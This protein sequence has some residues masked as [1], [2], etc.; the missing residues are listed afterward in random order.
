MNQVALTI[1]SDID[2]EGQ[3]FVEIGVADVRTPERGMKAGLV[4]SRAGADPWLTAEGWGPQPPTVNLP[5]A[6][7]TKPGTR[8]LLLLLPRTWAGRIQ[9]Y[10]MIKI[11][12]PALG[13][14]GAVAWVWSGAT[15]PLERDIEEPEQLPPPPPV[16][17]PPLPPPLPPPPIDLPPV[18][19]PVVIDP[20]REEL[21][22]EE[23]HWWTR[24][25]V[26]L[27]IA[28]AV[29]AVAVA[30]YVLMQGEESPPEDTQT[31]EEIF[32]EA[33]DELANGN[34]EGGGALMRRAADMGLA[35]ANMLIADA[36]N[37]SLPQ[38][39]NVCLADSTNIGAVPL[40]LDRYTKACEGGWAEAPARIEP[41]EAWMEQEADNP[42]SPYRTPA[43]IGLSLVGRVKQACGLE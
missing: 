38:T 6:I 19:P 25:W 42:N 31:A 29:L 26:W 35:A 21:P 18:D 11:S 34:C 3:E 8:P 15:M 13:F 33:N 10:D 16:V 5:V 41:F 37:P 36:A 12:C 43:Q 30:A 2:D 27:L 7:G 20:I 28:L 24:W 40:A 1:L 14:E 9:P 22:I 39:M 32:D 23:S 17:T 4:V